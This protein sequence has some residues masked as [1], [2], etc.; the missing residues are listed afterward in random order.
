MPGLG[1]KKKDNVS[2]VDIPIG[3]LPQLS[4]EMQLSIM[5]RVKHGEISIDDALNQARKEREQLLHEQPQKNTTQQYNF[6]VHKHSHY[7]WQKR[8]LQ[9]DFKNKMLCSI[10]KGIINRQLPFS[11]VKSCD[12]GVGSR[13][14][15]SF[16][17]HHDY[18][19]EATSLEDK[20]KMM[21]LVNQII[22]GN[23]YSDS[24]DENSESHQEP[25][26]SQSLKEGVLLLHRGGLAS[27]KWVK[28]QA[29]LH[30]GEL[31]LVPF[32]QRSNIDGDM[33]SSVPLS[34]VI[35]LSDGDTS[36]Q[37]PYGFDTFVLFT[38]R[39]EYQFKVPAPEEAVSPGAVQKERDAWVKAIDKLCSHWKRKSRSEHMFAESKSL[40]QI[41]I[42]EDVNDSSDS[43]KPV[44]PVVKESPPLVIPAPPPLP[45]KLIS[46]FK[47]SRTKAFHWDLIGSEKIAKTF[48]VQ[49]KSRRPEIDTSRLYDQFAVKDLG[50]FATTDSSSSQHIMLNQKIA[51]NF[52]F[53]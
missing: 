7:R 28:Y 6:S 50:I 33:T 48:W 53:M 41:S 42:P 25:Q 4:N 18:E 20:H 38:H 22:H 51:H 16:K 27:F 1:S 44:S 17:G 52:S 12:D 24:E 11:I 40:Q 15:I 49:E 5:N 19:L 2:K 37:K 26:A 32:R 46:T 10:E 21:Q 8:V 43:Q 14:S 34:T 30:P 45:V 31:T 47:K 36:V 3:D 35:H 39:N 9:I 13:F 29:Q 23:I